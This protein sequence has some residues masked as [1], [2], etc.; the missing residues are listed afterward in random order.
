[1]LSMYVYLASVT[2]NII[3][4]RCARMAA[5]RLLFSMV[6][7]STMLMVAV[8]VVAVLVVAVI[9]PTGQTSGK[10]HPVPKADV[11]GAGQLRGCLPG[12]HVLDATETLLASFGPGG[13]R[14]GRGLDLLQRDHGPGGTSGI[15]TGTT[16]WQ[17]GGC[18]AEG[19][20]AHVNCPD[21]GLR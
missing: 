15:G 1:F 8:L 21:P 10:F 12:H 3:R 6:P 9:M 2:W 16:G 18:T 17:E 5:S 14:A 19:C 20:R 7:M 4:P 13:A 11:R